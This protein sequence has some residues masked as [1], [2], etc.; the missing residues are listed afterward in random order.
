MG[1]HWSEILGFNYTRDSDTAP[2]R[3]VFDPAPFMG[4]QGGYGSSADKF[5]D[6]FLHGEHGPQGAP[7]YPGEPQTM[8]SAPN[9]LMADVGEFVNKFQMPFPVS[10]GE[11]E[12]YRIGGMPLLPGL[13]NKLLAEGQGR[14]VPPEG[15]MNAFLD[16]G[17]LTPAALGAGIVKRIKRPKTEPIFEAVH[18]SQEP[19]TGTNPAAWGTGAPGVDNARAAALR[20][21]E[22]MPQA[23]DRTYFYPPMREN[24]LQIEPGVGQQM[25]R[26]DLRGIY[27]PNNATSSVNARI[28]ARAKEIAD[29]SDWPSD[30]GVQQ[31]AREI[32]IKESGYSG[33]RNPQTGVIASFEPQKTT[34]VGS[35]ADQGINPRQTQPVIQGPPTPS[36][37][38]GG[39][40]AQDPAFLV[41]RTVMDRKTKANREQVARV[42]AGVEKYRQTH[43]QIDGWKP[44]NPV[45]S[46]DADGKLQWSP[47]A[48]SGF[49]YHIDPATGKEYVRGSAARESK[50]DEMS[51][52]MVGDLDDA[53]A[54]ADRG[55]KKAEKILK[56]LDW[57]NAVRKKVRDHFGSGGSLYGD[58][59]AAT[60]PKTALAQNF[61]MADDAFKR[62]MKGEFDPAIKNLEKHIAEGGTVKTFDAR[63][64]IRKGNEKLYGTHTPRI[65]ASL[66]DL[67]RHI[68]PGDVPKVRNYGGNWTGT[69]K[70][71][72]IDVWAGRSSQRHAGRPRVIPAQGKVEGRWMPKE[73]TLA[74]AQRKADQGVDVELQTTG[75]Y[76]MGVDAM[77]RAVEKLQAKYSGRFDDVTP[78]DFQAFEWLY[79]KDIWEANKYTRPQKEVNAVDLMAKDPRQLYRAS[80]SPTTQGAPAPAAVQN[81]LTGLRQGIDDPN[82]LTTARATEGQYAGMPELSIGHETSAP[83]GWNPNQLVQNVAREAQAR[84]Q[85][86]AMLSRR[87]DITD[88]NARPGME[89]YFNPGAIADRPAVGPPTPVQKRIELALAR[90]GI[91]GST[92]LQGPPRSVPNAFMGP[93]NPAAI[94]SPVGVQAMF[95]PEITAR[96]NYELAPG[97]TVD[98]V[99]QDPELVRL[100]TREQRARFRRAVEEIKQIKEV[101]MVSPYEYDTLH[102]GQETYGKAVQPEVGPPT[103]QVSFGARGVENRLIDWL[104]R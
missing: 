71:P 96:F 29:Q 67:F 95:S 98:R 62:F 49:D 80:I 82:V 97:I 48:D 92:A 93:P 16:V 77:T 78:D 36:G 73:G 64:Y 6:W 1:E 25:H 76:G 34:H 63:P 26:A 21:Q 43:R 69:S 42:E 79:E 35:L 5:G 24:A 10:A 33:Y 13:G 9:S 74:E 68:N 58:L 61:D 46:K 100:L 86:D 20:G 27:N 28:N 101:Q 3:S 12:G 30:P 19:R 55:D 90:Q 52:G 89:A 59:Q 85:M 40:V 4:P 14:Y 81:M 2:G 15:E 54:R 23:P 84:N 65:M 11:G 8:R 72:T 45:F 104:G 70:D 7:V 102:F 18:M 53:L 47:S 32:A 60:S 44:F 38:M 31:T 83:V 17:S 99:L 94:D 103:P 56:G 87:T 88:P 51:D 57:Y 39:P 50:I 66:V 75:A 91:E 37:R 41:P 22:G